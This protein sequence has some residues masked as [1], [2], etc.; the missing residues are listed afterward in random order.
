MLTITFCFIFFSGDDDYFSSDFDDAK[1]AELWS[2]FNKPVLVLHSDEDEF[3]PEHV[4]QADQNK[5]F[6]GASPMVSPLSGLIP[7]AGHTVEEEAAREWLGKKVVEFL[8]T[9]KN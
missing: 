5:R 7:D 8:G 1:L 3:V 2:R 9:L 4:D 6:Q